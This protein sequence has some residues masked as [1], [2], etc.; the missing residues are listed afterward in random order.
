MITLIICTYNRAKTL[1]VTLEDLARVALPQNHA[2]ELL[3]I[4]NN[5]SDNTAEVVSQ[6]KQTAPFPVCYILETQQG[7]SHAR[8]RGIREAGGE[9]I[10]FTDDDVRIETDW[11]TALAAHL[12]E[13]TIGAFGGRVLPVWPARLP[14]WVATEG[15]LLQ[16]GVFLH[17]EPGQTS[18]ELT[19]EDPEPFGC[20]MAFHASLFREHGAFRTDLGRIGGKLLAGEDSEMFSRLRAAGVPL[21]YVAEA[22][23]HHPVEERRLQIGYLIRW[24]YWAGYGEGRTSPYQKGRAFLGIPLY[25]LRSLIV[26]GV[27][28]LRQA[29]LTNAPA[30]TFQFGT[31]CAQVGF[32]MGA[33]FG[34]TE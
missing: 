23:V 29:V 17:Y 2:I 13:H 16:H 3:V 24:K 25:R 4:D 22:L 8:N 9:W 34:R 21:Y 32:V 11:L 31:V 10:L 18:R 30:T 5:S 20:N 15:P 33:W 26:A 14:R 12:T 28:C 6:F 7:L 27:E 1:N 19:A